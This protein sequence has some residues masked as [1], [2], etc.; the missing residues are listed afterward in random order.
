MPIF[1]LLL[2]LLFVPQLIDHG[3]SRA[4]PQN[5]GNGTQDLPHC[6][7]FQMQVVQTLYRDRGAYHRRLQEAR[8]NRLH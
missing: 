4:G 8:M 5:Q 7:R 2:S 3:S 6:A 1:V